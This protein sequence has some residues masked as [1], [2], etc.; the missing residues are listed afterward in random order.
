VGEPHVTTEAIFQLYEIAV[1]AADS[2]GEHEAFV[3]EADLIAHEERMDA[4]MTEVARLLSLLAQAPSTT[5]ASIA[6]K[7]RIAVDLARKD[8]AEQS[9]EWKLVSGALRD[10]AAFVT[11]FVPHS[12]TEVAS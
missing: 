7:L 11:A 6:G 5:L 2:L 12:V 4:A 8:G 9:A 10:V 1:S 3:S